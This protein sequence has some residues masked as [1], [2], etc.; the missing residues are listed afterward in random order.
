MVVRTPPLSSLRRGFLP[1]I[2]HPLPLNQR[3][4]QQLLESITT[5][6]RKNLD[7]EHPYETDETD[8][9]STN[10]NT[11]ASSKSDS[12]EPPSATSH[13]PTDRH[14]RAI[15]SNPLFAH[16]RN[17]NA[18]TAILTPRT[19]PFDV[20][21][22]AVSKGLMTTRRA[23]GF[24]ATVRSQ[25]LAE[26]PDNIRQRMGASGGGL[27]VLRWLRAS[28]QENSLDFLGDPALARVIVPF[29]YAEGLQEVAWGWLARLAARA[30]ELEF[31]MTPGKANAQTLSRLMS[32]IIDENSELGSPSPFSLDGSF[33]A[34]AK[35]NGMLPRENPAVTAAVKNSWAKLSWASTVDAVGRPKPSVTLFENFVDI[36]R[37]LN[38]PLD[39]AH[40][41]LHHPTAPTHSAAI[42]YLRLRR[43]IVQDMSNMKPRLQQRVLCLVLDAAERLNQTGQ[44]AE[45]PW[46]ERLRS[47]I[48]ERLNL[49]VLNLQVGETLNSSIPI[50]KGF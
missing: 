46:V 33:A 17:A 6:F 19:S 36:G 31:E 48:Y 41:D 13:R 42:E 43:Q 34:L 49:G 2:H 32:A 45:A 1:Q 16:P 5:S 26:S 14:L 3:E 37:P 40:L 44:V 15:L 30:T 7:R 38:L 21:D 10:T 11:Q 23:A 24:L 22:S 50:Q 29:L 28:G 35:A 4:S 39:L 9:T 18:G 27:C 47:A 8:E 25:L 12:A 20:F